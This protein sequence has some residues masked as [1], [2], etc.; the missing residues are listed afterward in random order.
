MIFAMLLQSGVCAQSVFHDASGRTLAV[1][2][3]P[4]MTHDEA[5]PAAPDAPTVPETPDAPAAPE[6]SPDA[7]GSK[8]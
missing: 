3:C 8:T 1:M 5:A 4:R 7:P 2:V 6:A